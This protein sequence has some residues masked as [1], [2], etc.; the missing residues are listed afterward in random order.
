MINRA[1]EGSLRYE[2]VARELAR[3]GRFMRRIL[4][5]AFLEGFAERRQ[6][7]HEIIRRMLALEDTTY[8]FLFT[9]DKNDTR[10]KQRQ[11]MLQYMC[12]VA[13]GLPPFNTRVVGVA[14]DK[15]NNVYDYVF[16]NKPD[17]TAK[18]EKLKKQIQADFGIF[19]SPV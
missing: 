14:T 17:W 10:K 8:C 13:R 12:F 19:V 15:R 5:Q 3:P 7:N 11:M 18:D 2:L 16:L 6:N 9:N 1:H 4:S